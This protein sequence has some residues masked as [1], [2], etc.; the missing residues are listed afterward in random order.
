MA[1]RP[2]MSG[3]NPAGRADR[4]SSAPRVGLIVLAGRGEPPELRTPTRLAPQAAADAN[5]TRHAHP[6][7][8]YPTAAFAAARRIGGWPD[9]SG[10]WCRSP[11]EA[12]S[13]TAPAARTPCS[14]SNRRSCRTPYRAAS[15]QLVQRRTH[16]ANPGR[17]LRTQPRAQQQRP[18]STHRPADE[19]HPRRIQ[20]L[21]RQHRYQLVEHHRPRVLAVG[22]PM[23]VAVTA[24]DGDHG[25]SRP[26][27]L[28]QL[29]ESVF[30]AEIHHLVR[31]L[32]SCSAI[33]GRNGPV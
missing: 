18:V 30:D 27:R 28:D 4:P 9:R 15:K 8:S 16:R 3:R 1:R 6:P 10:R 26:T 11:P 19:S 21:G 31:P 7:R 13:T 14:W 12:E 25:K 22:P 20:P 24:V 23:P 17:P 5:T 2:S 32:F 29:G 33:T